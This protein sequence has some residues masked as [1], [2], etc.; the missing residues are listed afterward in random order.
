MKKLLAVLLVAVLAATP[1]SVAVSAADETTYT[2]R[3]INF[4]SGETI[5]DYIS[6]PA[7]NTKESQRKAKFSLISMVGPNGTESNALK[8]DGTI[9]QDVTTIID[10]TYTR[11]NPSSSNDKYFCGYKITKNSNYRFSAWFKMDG[12]V[13]QKPSTANLTYSYKSMNSDKATS[14]VG[15]VGTVSVPFADK[16]YD[17]PGKWIQVVTY[18]T[19]DYVDNT[20]TRPIG[21]SVDFGTTLKGTVYMDDMEIVQ[22]PEIKQFGA[23]ETVQTI[24]FD[25]NRPYSFD[26][27]AFSVAN[28]ADVP[29]GT[30]NA[31]KIAAGTYNK[32]AVININGTLNAQTDPAFAVPVISGNSYV[33]S[34]KVFVPSHENQF[35]YSAIMAGYG[36]SSG[37]AEELRID[38]TVLNNTA[39]YDKWVT[40]N[41][42]FT[43][44][45]SK[46]GVTVNFGTTVVAD[47]YLDDITL[48]NVTQTV[49]N[50]FTAPTTVQIRKE[51]GEVSQALRFK[52]TLN[53]DALQ[54]AL[55]GYELVEYG[56]LT[57]LQKN[58]TAG[59]SVD[60]FAEG[61]KN[62][63]DGKNIYIGRAFVKSTGTDL[64][65]DENE[66]GS[67]VYTAALTN[68]G[69]KSNGEMNYNVWGAEYYV[70]PYIVLR[71]YTKS[72]EAYEYFYG[73]AVA[74]SASVFGV[75]NE[76]LNDE[77]AK[78]D[79]K[80][81]VN[82]K[83]EVA[84]IKEAYDKCYPAQG[85]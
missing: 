67:I 27:G 9:N 18:F 73:D 36:Q 60:Y 11:T 75:M 10:Y 3:V 30:S 62:T 55:P 47:V 56:C 82:A 43:A 53:R 69:V 23:A 66:D 37:I 54:A 6:I 49:A 59:T 14:V 29:S 21:L 12:N 17:N 35:G 84:E 74:G 79:D 33:L 8:I 7:N 83:L 22:I 39:N 34:A 46:V 45:S 24:T 15:T 70:R 25:D 41:K 81:Y 48:T 1:L 4:D 31:L 32:N 61:T 38:K 57:T 2:P 20:A 77:T 71:N 19:T 64:V 85:Q 72:G 58:V 80:A 76:I 52:V 78:A 65:F 26:H 28:A 63:V 51:A 68:I 40:V 44:Q 13:T 42:T 50:A 5:D 16:L